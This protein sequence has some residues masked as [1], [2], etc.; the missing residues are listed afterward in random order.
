MLKWNLSMG[1]SQILG[2]SRECQGPNAAMVIE[3]QH[4]VLDGLGFGT[5]QTGFKSSV[6]PL[7]K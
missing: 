4:G 3:K 7:E 6:S 1:S 2:Y 5:T